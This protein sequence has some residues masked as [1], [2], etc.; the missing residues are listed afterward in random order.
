M[1]PISRMFGHKLR[2]LAPYVLNVVINRARQRLDTEFAL[3]LAAWWGIDIGSHTQFCGLPLLQ[4]HP[5]AKIVIGTH[6]IFRSAEWSNTIGLNRRC[7]IAGARDARI[8]IGNHCGFSG[9]V[10]A[11]SESITIGDRVLCGGNCTILDSDR[12]HLNAIAR[13]G[14]EKSPTAPI[15]IEDD[16]FLGMNVVVLK[17]C[18]IGKGT[19]VGVG[20]LVTRSLPAG[21]LAAGRPARVIREINN[22]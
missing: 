19:V 14:N 8:T 5:T 21:V 4:R 20:S 3:M 17:G 10:I 11:A 15:V 2:D 1:S 12:H 13:S 22:F 6:A 7:F 9:T 16:V 18:T